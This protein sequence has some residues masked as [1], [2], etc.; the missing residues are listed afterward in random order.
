M[1]TEVESIEEIRA[2]AWTFQGQNPPDGAVKIAEETRRGQK[3]WY[4][5]TPDGKYYYETES[6]RKWKNKIEKWAK[7]QARKKH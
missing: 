2:K 5:R 7:E 3:Q 1:K 6:G 4:Y